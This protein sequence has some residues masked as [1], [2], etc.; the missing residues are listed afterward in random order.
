M[1]SYIQ[2]STGDVVIR[3]TLV[4]CM[5][6]YWLRVTLM[7]LVWQERGMSAD[8]VLAVGGF[9]V[10]VHGTYAYC[11]ASAASS[12]DGGQGIYYAGLA[13]YVLGSYLNTWSEVDR[14]LWKKDK[15]NKGK[16]YTK[17]LWRY[18]MHINYFGDVVLFTGWP[19]LR[20]I[21]GACCPLS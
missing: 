18:S 7:S 16:L 19:S 14:C 2:A 12:K 20:K 3:S 8:E 1:E 15:R 13:L 17:G 10:Y 6:G 11:G 9:L 21:S 4:G 5:A